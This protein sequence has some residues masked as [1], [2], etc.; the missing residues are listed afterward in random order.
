MRTG[1]LD[2]EGAELY[3][4]VRGSGPGLVLIPGAG[5][6]AGYFSGVAEELCDAFTVI[7]Y[8]R[9]GNS[10]STGRTGTAMVLAEQA[11]DAKALID[12]LADGKALVFG[13]SG[14]GIVALDLC[15]RYPDSVIATIAHEP[16]VFSLLDADV[17]GADFYAQMS[18]LYRQVGTEVM[19]RQLAAAMGDGGAFL[20][21]DDL[22]GRF[23][24]NLDH[25]FDGEWDAWEAF[26]PDVEALT[27][28]GAPP[29]VLAGAA[30]N[31]GLFNSLPAVRIAARVGASWLE[32][33][34]IHLEFLVRPSGFSAA[35]RAAC[36][37]LYTSTQGDVPGVWTRPVQG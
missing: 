14:G 24:G 2:V 22:L 17:P 16:P 12:G 5:G 4:E 3:H 7:T 21:P 10:R 33:P 6:D 20:W 19:G 36:T 30:A 25:L 23:M 18:G 9:R 29:L 35:L 31:R 26:S 8:D 13:S 27:A 11:D 32:F 1:R 15:A 34:G 37:H 28:A